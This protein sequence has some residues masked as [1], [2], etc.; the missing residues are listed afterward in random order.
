MAS[1][2][3]ASQG[4][5]LTLEGIDMQLPTGANEL[6]KR[7]V[8]RILR[9]DITAAGVA[10]LIHGGADPNVGITL[11]SD[12]RLHMSVLALAMDTDSRTSCT[13]PLTARI[14]EASVILPLW[15]TRQ[16]HEEIMTA[17]LAGGAHVDGD[18]GQ[19]VVPIRMAK[20]SLNLTALNVL[21]A[22]NVTVRGLGVWPILF[23]FVSPSPPSLN[24]RRKRS[25]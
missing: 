25:H 1:D 6:T 16:H 11:N 8:Q 22:N 13:S 7:L 24:Q 18:R 4:R 14:G 17:L 21:L 10:D 19:I 3:A 2:S 9:R 5:P 23:C 20:S 12:G 15:P